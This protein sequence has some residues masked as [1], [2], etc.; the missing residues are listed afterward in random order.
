VVRPDNL[1]RYRSTRSQAGKECPVDIDRFLAARSSGSRPYS[2]KTL[3]QYR[4]N[5]GRI[6]SWLDAEGLDLEHLTPKDFQ[7]F[8]SPSWGAAHCSVMLC[9]LK[10]YLRW[11]YGETH[12]LLALKLARPE[13]P[14]PRTLTTDDILACF[15][16]LNPKRRSD[17]RTAAMLSLALET[18]L[19]SAELC[20]LRLGEIDV[21]HMHGSTRIKGGRIGPFIFSETTRD[22]IQKWLPDRDALAPDSPLLFVSEDGRIIRREAWRWVCWRLAKRAGIQR[23]S[24]HALRRAMACQMIQNGASDR[25]T[26]SLGRWKNVGM[27]TLYTRA[28]Q[29]EPAR[30]LLPLAQMRLRDAA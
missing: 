20:N 1:A 3:I 4:Y 18:G 19:R 26:A 28:L 13:Q 17:R 27:V 16:T 25:M 22:F 14:V 12:P 29:L 24:P 11:R 23:F 8:F 7:R 10:S 9:S 2:P 5:L 21:E 15:A 30:G 6:G